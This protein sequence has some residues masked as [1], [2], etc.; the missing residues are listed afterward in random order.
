MVR[1]PI[2]IYTYIDATLTCTNI[3]AFVYLLEQ[4]IIGSEVQ[5]TCIWIDSSLLDWWCIHVSVLANWW[6]NS[7]NSINRLYPNIEVSMHDGIFFFRLTCLSGHSITALISEGSKLSIY[8]TDRLTSSIRCD[9]IY[10]WCHWSFSALMVQSSI[11]WSVCLIN[12]CKRPVQQSHQWLTDT[13][14]VT[15]LKWSNDT[16]GVDDFIS[17]HFIIMIYLTLIPTLTRMDH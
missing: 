7:I 10:E 16:T 9:R 4:A 5:W 12:Q 3:N 17:F 14:N 11:S 13:I 8:Y 15:D 2:Y 1:E 6:P